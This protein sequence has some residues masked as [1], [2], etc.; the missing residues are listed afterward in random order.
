MF[1]DHSGFDASTI[2]SRHRFLGNNKQ[3][4]MKTHTPDKKNRK[5]NRCVQSLVTSN[6][7]VKT[8]ECSGYF[9]LRLPST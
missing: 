3:I 5:I 1:T 6:V 9:F 8:I 7:N 2:L 4:S